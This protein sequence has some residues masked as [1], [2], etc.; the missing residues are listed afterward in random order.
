M[1]KQIVPTHPFR[2]PL[3]QSSRKAVPR[4]SPERPI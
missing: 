3:N 1:A 4:G 2:I